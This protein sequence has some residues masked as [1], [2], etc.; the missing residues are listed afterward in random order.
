MN[1]MDL[2]DD[3]LDLIFEMA[4][5]M[6]GEENVMLPVSEW[7]EEDWMREYGPPW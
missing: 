5:V 2:P 7:T 1:L 3:I 4:F 6:E